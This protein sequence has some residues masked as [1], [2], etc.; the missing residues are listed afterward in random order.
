MQDW[1]GVPV[2]RMVKNEIEAVLKLA[3]TLNQRV[4]GQRHALEMIASR[5]QTSRAKLDNPNKPI[6]VFMLCGPSGVGKTETALTLAEALY[7]GEQNVI[8]INMSEF[9]E[10]HTVS[11]LK[12]SPPGYVG[13]GEGGVLTEAVRRRPYSVVLLDEV[14]KAHPDVH[15]I[16][17]Q[18]FDKGWMEDGEGRRID[19]KNTIILLTS[20]VGTDLIMNMCKDPELMPEPEG[21]AKGLRE[22]LLKV[23]PAALLGRLVVIPV[24]PAR[25]RDARQSI[26]R[27]QLGRIAKR[28]AEHHK[29]PFTYDDAAVSL[30]VSRCT[31]IESGGRMIDAIL[32]NTVLPAI[33][34][35]FLTRTMAGSELNGVCLAV[36]GGDFEYQFS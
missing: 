20:N 12:G 27:L 22:P 30:I 2:G 7:G 13:Y 9:Q 26:V 31:E 33:S 29:I 11:T 16:F 3:E 24:L 19:F 28:V 18:V 36:A 35:E 5:I 1:T 4:I 8:T 25:R 6:G 10:A 23:F 21:I 17:F 15:E 14:E 32:T 34:R